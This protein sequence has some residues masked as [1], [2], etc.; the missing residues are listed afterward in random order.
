MRGDGSRGNLC[1]PSLTWPPSSG[2]QITNLGP[3]KE[4]GTCQGYMDL[5][6]QLRLPPQPLWVPSA[7]TSSFPEGPVFEWDTRQ[8]PLVRLATTGLPGAGQFSPLP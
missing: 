8:A 7:K 6:A 3:R 2:R 1:L 4:K 5:P